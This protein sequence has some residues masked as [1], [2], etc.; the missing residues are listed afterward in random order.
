M[1]DHLEASYCADHIYHCSSTILR[2][3]CVWSHDHSE[4][5]EHRQRGWGGSGC[6]TT[7]AEGASAHAQLPLLQHGDILVHHQ[8]PADT[9][10]PICPPHDLSA[11]A[12]TTP[13]P[14]L[15][16]ATSQ[17]RFFRS[18]IELQ[19]QT[20]ELDWA[21][22]MLIVNEYF[23]NVLLLVGLPALQSVAFMSTTEPM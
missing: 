9:P 16:A 1:I 21:L 3:V 18:P 2:R 23:G 4:R 10:F 12:C 13:T 15:T 7:T 22:C 20:G 6:L 11:I 17:L 19:L 8:R 5:G 14:A